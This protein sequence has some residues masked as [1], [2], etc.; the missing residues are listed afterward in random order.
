MLLHVQ[1]KVLHNVTH[2]LAASTDLH[3]LKAFLMSPDAAATFWDK[4]NIIRV[5]STSN[6]ISCSKCHNF[7]MHMPIF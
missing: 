2:A 5:S 4:F 3:T 1:Y 6:K 7:F